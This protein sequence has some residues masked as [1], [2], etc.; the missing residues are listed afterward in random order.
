MDLS[1][2]AQKY[3]QKIA[4]NSQEQNPNFLPVGNYLIII[5]IRNCLVFTLT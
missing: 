1:T 2:T 5:I 4:G 3:Y